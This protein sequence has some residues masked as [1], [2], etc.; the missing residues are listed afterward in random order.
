LLLNDPTIGI[1]IEEQEASASFSEDEGLI[2]LM[3][4]NII[5]LSD[6]ASDT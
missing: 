6:D 2:F 1:L 5:V 3:D 4:E